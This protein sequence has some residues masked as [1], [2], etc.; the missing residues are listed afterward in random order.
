MVRQAGPYFRGKIGYDPDAVAKQW[1]DRAGTVDILEQAR[2]AL[3]GLATWEPAAMEEALRVLAE[4][5]GFG[6]KAGRVFQPLRV[7]LT[8][9]AASPGIFDVLLLLGRDRS[10]ARID[11]AIAYLRAPAESSVA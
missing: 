11:D 8:G 4:R 5:L 7:A 2:N 9:M 1:K 3:A 10:M 6:D